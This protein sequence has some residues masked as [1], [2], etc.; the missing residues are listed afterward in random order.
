MPNEMIKTYRALNYKQMGVRAGWWCGGG[1]GEFAGDLSPGK[2]TAMGFSQQYR[3]WLFK[4]QKIGKQPQKDKS[5]PFFDS[6]IKEEPESK[7]HVYYNSWKRRAL[8]KEYGYSQWPWKRT[9][10]L[11]SV[12]AAWCHWEQRRWQPRISQ[13]SG[14]EFFLRKSD[15][16]RLL[17]GPSYHR[18]HSF[19]LPPWN[20]SF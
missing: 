14:F 11:A 18:T 16:S 10:K 1:R 8:L 19:S 5:P 15:I 6:N 9:R 17:S 2:L 20:L 12:I 3:K 7:I 13:G 4:Q